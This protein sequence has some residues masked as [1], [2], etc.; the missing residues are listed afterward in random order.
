M[1]RHDMKESRMP[2]TASAAASRSGCSWRDPSSRSPAAPACSSRLAV[3]ASTLTDG[4]ATGVEVY[5]GQ[6]WAVIGGILVGAGLVGLALA[7]TLAAL[8]AVVAPRAIGSKP[9]RSSPPPRGRRGRGDR[10]RIPCRARAA[11]APDGAAPATAAADPEVAFAAEARRVP[12][13][14]GDAPRLTAREER[15]GA[16]ARPGSFFVRRLR[17]R[18]ARVAMTVTSRSTAKTGRAT[19]P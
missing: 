3:M 16:A 5:A 2:T 11:A 13:R 15:P 19:R 18:R 12:D 9:S 7:L 4:S 10:S 6:T 8:R 14:R 17:R 1:T